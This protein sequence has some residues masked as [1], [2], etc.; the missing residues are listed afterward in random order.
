M[1]L[2]WLLLHGFLPMW[3]RAGVAAAQYALWGL[4]LVAAGFLFVWR[5]AWLAADFG[6]Q[7][8]VTTAG[9]VFLVGAIIFRLHIA[10]YLP[11]SVQ[12]G[13]PEIDLHGHPQHLITEGPYAHTRHPRYIQI[14]LA[15]TGWALLANFAAGYVAALLWAP[16]MLLIVRLEEDELHRRFP[17]EYEDYCARVA[18][19]WPHTPPDT[20]GLKVGTHDMREVRS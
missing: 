20:H 18:R 8:L 19:F 3:R 6:F 1:L 13:L 2:Y 7:P 15:L 4:V 12:L 5:E 17:G 10:R 14:A 11:W 16:L 9:V